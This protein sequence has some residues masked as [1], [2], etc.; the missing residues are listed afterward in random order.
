MKR[1]LSIVIISAISCGAHTAFSQSVASKVAIG[2]G[3]SHGV[4]SQE[5]QQQIRLAQ[6]KDQL[7]QAIKDN[8]ANIEEIKRQIKQLE[9]QMK[10]K[11][12]PTTSYDVET[13]KRYY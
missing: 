1:I 4:I 11:G 5:Q 9:K 3:V 2:K 12:L 13:E 8:A 10:R 6:L 7:N